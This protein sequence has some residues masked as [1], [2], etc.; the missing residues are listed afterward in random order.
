LTKERFEISLAAHQ[1]REWNAEMSKENRK[2][3]CKLS[4]DEVKNHF[5]DYAELVFNPRFVCGNCLRASREKQ[6]LCKPRKMGKKSEK[7]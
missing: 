1:K 2:K 7:R 5:G 4:K 3:F 6:N